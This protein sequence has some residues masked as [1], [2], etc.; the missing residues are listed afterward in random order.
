MDEEQRSS[1]ESLCAQHGFKLH[2][3]EVVE[4]ILTLTTLGP[5]PDPSS[6]LDLGQSLRAAGFRWVA[7]DLELGV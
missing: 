7:L 1:V 3:A 5:L 2:N 6:L 4:R